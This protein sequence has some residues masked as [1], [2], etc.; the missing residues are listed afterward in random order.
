MIFDAVAPQS[1]ELCTERLTES[2]GILLFDNAFL[3]VADDFVLRL[4]IELLELMQGPLVKT[5][6]PAHTSPLRLNKCGL[7]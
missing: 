5:I 3:Q 2:P 1:H 6:G 4:A 7:D